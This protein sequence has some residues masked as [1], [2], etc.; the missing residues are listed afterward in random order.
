MIAIIR[1]VLPLGWLSVHEALH[2][3]KTLLDPQ[4]LILASFAQLA[5]DRR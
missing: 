5:I 1:A 3:F 4:T 2:E